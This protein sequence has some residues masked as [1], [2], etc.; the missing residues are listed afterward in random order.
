[1]R[2]VPL[3]VVRVN[4]E[5]VRHAGPCSSLSPLASG[6]ADELPSAKELTAR[7]RRMEAESLEREAGLAR[8]AP[9]AV[10]VAPVVV[11]FLALAAGWAIVGHA[12]GGWLGVVLMWT[13]WPAVAVVVG[14]VFGWVGA[15]AVALLAAGCLVAL[16]MLAVGE[17]WLSPVIA[18]SVAAATTAA[19]AG[20]V[21]VARRFVTAYRAAGA[22]RRQDAYVELRAA[23]ARTAA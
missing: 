17:G 4:G 11:M 22:Q 23:R 5:P 1:M 8:V 14:A 3:R 19:V 18:V 10:V 20:W 16:G 12:L 2:G 6:V 9:L 15:G 21:V 13:A 7:A